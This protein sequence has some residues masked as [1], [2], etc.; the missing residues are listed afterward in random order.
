MPIQNH[1]R[2]ISPMALFTAVALVGLWYGLVT[3]I[4]WLF[5]GRFS[6]S[7]LGWLTIFIIVLFGVLAGYYWQCFAK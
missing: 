4:R 3:M 1:F 2:V 6:D 7:Q 5:I